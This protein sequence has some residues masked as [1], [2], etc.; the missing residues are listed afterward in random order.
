MFDSIGR[1][2]VVIVEIQQ[3]ICQ[4]VYGNSPCTAA[5]G[6]TGSRKCFNTRAT[7]QDLANYDDDGDPIIL[8]FAKPNA[9]L[10]QNINLIP[11]VQS[12][13]T[14]PTRINI[15]GRLGKE[16]PLGLRAE[17]NITIG[18]HPHSDNIV[19]PYLS[20]RDYNPLERGTFWSKW[21]KRNPY[22]EGITLIVY[23]GYAGQNLE[24]MQSRLYVIDKITGPDSN[25][26]V[27]IR[28]T[29]VLRLADDDKSQYP[30]LTSGTLLTGI[31][32]TETT[33]LTLTGDVEASYTAYSTNAIRI[34]NEIIV[35]TSVAT[36]G[37][38]DLEFSGLTRGQYGTSATA[39]DEGDTAQACVYFD[40]VAPWQVVR[41]V[42]LDAGVPSAYIDYAAWVDEAT[43]WLGGLTVT[44][45]LS[46]PT[47]VNK[48]IGE[49]C[50]QC[51]FFVWFDERLRE[52]KFQAIKPAVGEVPLITEKNNLLQGQTKVDLRPELRA[53]EVWVSYLPRDYSQNQNERGNF[54]R[55]SARVSEDNF[56]P[57]RRVYELY[58]RWLSSQLQVNLLTFRLLARYKNPPVYVS[59][60]LD[61]KDRALSVGDPF[62]IEFR[63]FTDDTGAIE[64]RRY[65]VISAHES[66]PGETIIIEAQIFDYEID[67]KVGSWMIDAAPDYSV[68]TPAEKLAG[69]WWASDDGTVEGDPGYVWS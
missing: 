26:K 9:D 49:L 54:K 41:D 2:P 48:I 61:A 58:S 55:T 7:C 56:Y 21:L 1:I 44:N 42:L 23:E 68:A 65:Q 32:D 47:G 69:C 11:S 5:I 6:T 25:N 35:Y 52:I 53:S 15:G 18:D 34:G 63:G 31:T 36:N 57:E 39:H 27:S 33:L 13:Q 3:P 24:A 59:F 67:F 62:D 17:T 66:P 46:E 16:K 30:A 43:T 12:V 19:D 60:S 37:S 40:A 14:V 50:E 10:P 38:G 8:R 45:L 28:A 29:D 51:S 20:G 4:N 22:Y 64:R